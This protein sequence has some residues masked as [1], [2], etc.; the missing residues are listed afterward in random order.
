MK[1]LLTVLTAGVVLSGPRAGHAAFIQYAGGTY[2]QSFDSL[3]TSGANQTWANDSTITGWNLFGYAGTAITTYNSGNG[4][5]ATGNFYSFGTGT[6]S[7]WALGGVASAN[8]YFELARLLTAARG[9]GAYRAGAFRIIRAASD[10]SF[11]RKSGGCF[12]DS[13]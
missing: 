8:A 10:K 12:N 3:I 1:M 9:D 2:S 6:A 11:T 5:S 7:E 13:S 4:G